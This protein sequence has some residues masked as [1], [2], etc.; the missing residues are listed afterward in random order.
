MYNNYI[1]Q[2]VVS[3]LLSAKNE[4]I[5]WLKEEIKYLRQ[6]KLLDCWKRMIFLRD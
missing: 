4:E 1:P 6:T 2:K 5:N 3:E